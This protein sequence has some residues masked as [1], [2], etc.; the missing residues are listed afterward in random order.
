VDSLL[1][2]ESLLANLIPLND[3]RSSLLWKKSK[4]ILIGHLEE[5]QRNIAYR[6]SRI[7]RA[8]HAFKTYGNVA[9]RPLNRFANSEYDYPYA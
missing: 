6:V 9:V 1:A 4:Y 5:Y 7:A 8:E 2:L 3:E